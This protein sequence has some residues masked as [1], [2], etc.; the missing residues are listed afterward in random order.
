MSLRDSFRV[1][2]LGLFL[3]VSFVP[4]TIL[5]YWSIQSSQ[6]S[7]RGQVEYDLNALIDERVKVVESHYRDQKTRLAY[8]ATTEPV[9]GLLDYMISA[10]TNVGADSPLYASYLSVNMPMLEMLKTSS[11][12]IDLYLI[13]P[14][15]DIVVSVEQKSD[16]GT[17]L[18]DGPYSDS[19]LGTTFR[20]AMA[21]LEVSTSPHLPYAPSAN[22][23]S[24][25]IATPVFEDAQ[26]IGILAAQLRTHVLEEQ[27]TDF[28]GLGESGEVMFGERQAGG[29][30]VA[31]PLRHDPEATRTR[32]IG[33]GE[34]HSVPL[35]R[36]VLGDRGSGEFVDY[37]GV[38]SIAAWRYLP[39]LNWGMVLK[40]DTAEAFARANQQQAKFYLFAVASLVL[41]CL[42]ALYFSRRVST[43]VRGLLRATKALTRG[44]MSERLAENSRDEIGQLASAHNRM[45]DDLESKVAQ[46][47]RISKGD[48]SEDVEPRSVDD[49]LGLSLQRLVLS[50]RNTADIASDV[51]AGNLDVEVDI[52]GEADRLGQ[53]LQGMLNNLKRR[54]WLQ[55]ARHIVSETLR[56]QLNMQVLAERLVS[57]VSR[58]ID[59][60]MAVLYITEEDGSLWRYAGVANDLKDEFEHAVQLGEGLV[61]EVAQQREPRIVRDLP[62]QYFRIRSGLGEA[63]STSV[64]LYPV[65]H[66]GR[67]VAVFELGSFAGFNDSHREFLEAV[68]PA[69]GMRIAAIRA[70]EAQQ[71]LLEETLQQSA[72]LKRSEK[73]L[74]EQQELL[75]ARNEELQQQTDELN[76][77]R[78]DLQQ[79]GEELRVINEEL[80]DQ[81]KSIAKQNEA[82]E[83]ARQDAEQKALEVERASR[84]KSEFLANMSHELRTP[85][86]SL[87]ILA[88]GFADNEDNNLNAD[89]IEAGKIIHGSGRD[90]LELINGILDLSKIEAGKMIVNAGSF[91]IASFAKNLQ[92]QFAPI[93]ADKGVIF[94]VETAEDVPETIYSDEIKASQIVKNL[95]SNA[96]KF[97]RE[98]AVHLRIAT[99]SVDATKGFALAIAVE[100]SG[101]GIPDDKQALI[102]EAFQQADGSTSRNYGGT[103]LGLSICREMS[104][105]LGGEVQVV[106]TPGKGSVFTLYLP[107]RLPDADNV[108]HNENQP[109]LGTPTQIPI[110]A[111]PVGQIAS[112]KDDRDQISAND[113]VMLV[114]ED[115]PTFAGVVVDLV[116]KKGFKCVA[117]DSGNTGVQLA[118][119]YKPKGIL[120]DLGLPD[121]DGLD[122]ME[123]LK[124]G[125][126]TRHI[127]VHILSGRENHDAAACRNAIGVL[128]K[129]VSREA[130][131]GA[132]ARI[133]EITTDGV[134]ELL[135]VEDD[136]NTQRVIKRLMG[137]KRVNIEACSNGTD[138]LAALK[139]KR[140]DCV[141]LD[142]GLPDIDGVD[143]LEEVRAN[144]AIV[145]PP[146]IIYS[147]RDLSETDYEKL[148]SHTDSIVIKGARSEE[149]LTSEAS[150][151]L[152]SVM[153][154]QQPVDESRTEDTSIVEP[155]DLSGKTILLVDDDMRNVYALS[156]KL[157]QSG[158]DVVVA[159]DGSRALEKLEQHGDEIECVLMDVMM[160]IMDGIEATAEIRSQAQ[161]KDLPI[162]VLTAHAMS[163]DRDRCMAAGASDYMTKP[164]DV[165]RLLAS[166]KVWMC[167]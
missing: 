115:D 84:Y 67:T 50:L 18:L 71:T 47:N 153:R 27:F 100:D 124:T 92:R 30:L 111:K 95:L 130:L 116:R 154:E 62:P 89:Q 165:E 14:Q 117:T 9:M 148:R 40:I 94:S 113:P 75:E 42:A 93:A 97:T 106:S 22:R 125:T 5:G 156:R 96:F 129:P 119:Q 133:E 63:S 107:E 82:L 37:R 151:F 90:L 166:L 28:V 122:V 77:S 158:A 134:R 56:E 68:G 46:I 31:A 79:Q 159:Q 38:E 48:F 102:F 39:D 81:K 123:H 12:F 86:N 54:A 108:V 145:A 43:P 78:D 72:A 29:A 146:F 73:D 132:I 162:I 3:L 138:A 91:A 76:R 70:R 135:V 11:D 61:G 23:H 163:E 19:H 52:K 164:V 17:N 87:L 60:P 114:I 109:D 41:S 69:I 25:F 4:I 99:P 8:L 121:I 26:L 127:P 10:L 64:Y 149:R 120:L 104:R 59:A 58:V 65:V 137:S 103:G 126:D 13:S 6:A 152:H 15:G 34:K 85:L 150:L 32:A 118:R 49:T 161:F 105:M 1:K 66:T 7:L 20:L 136:S 57:E 144:D 2:L 142:L 45:L 98:G 83:R 140:Y 51:T 101:I 36:A 141:I 24:T 74:H 21:M 35:Q 112:I 131:S 143:L 110:E 33:F 80:E 53:A 155:S 16:F 167:K 88:K 160:P 128:S 157:K 55:K 139:D 147:G 44:N